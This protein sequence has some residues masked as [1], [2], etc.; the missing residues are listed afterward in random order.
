MAEKIYQ[1]FQDQCKHLKQGPNCMH[2]TSPKSIQLRQITEPCPNCGRKSD[3]RKGA[4][5]GACIGRGSYC[6]PFVY[7]DCDCEG[8]EKAG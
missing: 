7:E 6:Y 1:C 2:C 4:S 5:C 3:D 8:Y